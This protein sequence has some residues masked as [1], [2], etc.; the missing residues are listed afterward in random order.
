MGIDRDEDSLHD[1]VET[2]SGIFVS[3]SNTGTNPALSDTDGDGFDD[4]IE[5][6]A[7]TNPVN[8]RELPRLTADGTGAPRCSC[9]LAPRGLPAG[10]GL[11]CRAKPMSS[12]HSVGLM[13]ID[14]HRTASAPRPDAAPTYHS[15]TLTPMP[16]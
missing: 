11:V 14:V 10:D 12:T 6:L 9:P 3:A 15:S 2:N 8:P 13:W 5:V 1:G 16:T 7:G 4:G